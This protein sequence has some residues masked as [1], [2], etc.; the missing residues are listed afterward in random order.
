MTKPPKVTNQDTQT[1]T[2]LTEKTHE[3]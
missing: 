1:D 2:K 3:R